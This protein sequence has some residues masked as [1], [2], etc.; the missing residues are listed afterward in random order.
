ME[1][2]G[3]QFNEEEMVSMREAVNVGGKLSLDSFIELVTQEVI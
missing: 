3:F 2:L 1:R